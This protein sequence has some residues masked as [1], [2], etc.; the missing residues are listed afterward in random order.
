MGGSDMASKKSPATTKA[1]SKRPSAFISAPFTVDTTPLVRAVE[2]RGIEAIRLD[3]L[4]AGLSISDLLRQSMGRADYVIAV[5]GDAPNA[6][7]WYELGMASGMEKPVLLLAS[8]HG[9]LPFAASGLPYLTADLGNEK[10]IEFGLDQ[11]LSAPKARVTPQSAADRETHPIGPSADRL[12]EKLRDYRESGTS[13]ETQ[14]VDVVYAAIK[15]GG[16]STLS[17]ESR[18]EESRAADLAV[19]SGD[20][21]PWIGN[22]LVIEV[23][24]TLTGS[25]DLEQT[26]QRLSAVLDETRSPYGLLLYLAAKPA[27]LYAAS[28]DPRVMVMSVEDFII[29]LRD[30]GL[31]DLL[32]RTRNHIAHTRG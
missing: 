27:V 17:R 25:K 30:S 15:E 12:L 24:K 19:W 26:M 4:G 8:H 7:V 14:I 1:R 11:L 13:L 6:N 28:F 2:G 21:E 29:G 18:G 22:P 32:R 20:F 31:G 5:I 10:A 16:V 3:E 9:L 23:K